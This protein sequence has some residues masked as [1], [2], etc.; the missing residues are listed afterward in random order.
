[1]MQANKFFLIL[2]ATIL[3]A[4][5]QNSWQQ[6]A[7]VLMVISYLAFQDHLGT[8]QKDYSD[9]VLK[10]IK[11]LEEFASSQGLRKLIGR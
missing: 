7:M 9:D 3:S 1:M 2:C 6:I 10:R 11:E 8:R 5:I 4:I